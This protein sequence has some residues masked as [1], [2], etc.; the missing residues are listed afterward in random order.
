[1]L[2]FTSLQVSMIVGLFMS[3]SVNFSEFYDAE[4]WMKPVMIFVYIFITA[5]DMIFLYSITMIAE[6]AHESLKKLVQP[7]EEALI[8][9]VDVKE[10]EEMKI[11]VKNI[12]NVGPLNGNGY[13]DISRSTLTSVTSISI[14]YL[15][16][17][18][19]FRNI[20]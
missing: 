12:E 9:T 18:L 2:V 19:Q 15:I 1:M 13:F 14:T 3:V 20:E 17:L 16:I 11:L 8:R 10:R 4:P 7:L 5:Y 6:K